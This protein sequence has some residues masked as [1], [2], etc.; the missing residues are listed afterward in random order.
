MRLWLKIT[1]GISIS[2]L[3]VLIIGGYIFY[4]MLN[5][6]LP[7][8]QG[9]L[10]A[11]GLKEK[12]EIYRDSMAVPYIFANNDEDAAFAL[13]YVHAQERMFMMDL[14]RRAGAG[15]LSEVMGKE[16]I[17]FDIMF[18]TVGINR[19]VEKIKNKMNP[20]ALQLL[21]AYSKGVNYYIK[22]ARNK[23]TFEFDMLG[24]QPEEW[25]P[26][27]SLIVIR[28]MAWELNLSWWTDI[29]FT[30]LV[31][32]LGKENVEEIL[33]DYPEN[34]PTIIP[35]HLKKFTAISRTFLEIDK[36][37]RKFM[38]MDGTHIGSNNWVVNGKMSS[39]GKPI[40]ANDPHLAF[41]VPGKWYAAVIKSPNWDAAGVTL[42]GVPGIVI[43]KNKN[44][45]WVLT[46]I[47]NDDSDFYFEE[48]DSSGT[49]YFLDDK[50]NDLK[51]IEDTIFVR[52]DGPVP[53]IIKETHRGPVIS[54]IHS[55]NI[56]YNED[57]TTYPPISMRW[58]G[59]EVSDEAYAFLKIN[60]AANWKEFKSAV[61]LFNVPG[62]N[63]VYGDAE[64]NIGYIF[65][66]ALPL[67]GNGTLNSTT[68][69]FDGTTS[70]SDWTG[71]FNRDHV[72]VLY[73]PDQNFIASANN[74]T[75]KD[76]KYHITNLWEPPSRIERITE[77]LKSKTKHSVNDFMQY[78]MDIVSPYAKSIVSYFLGA[79]DSIDVKDDKLLLAL[80]LLKDW[81][82]KLDKFAQAPTIYLTT[83]K[84]LLN[85]VF[86]DKMG[87]DL[88]NQ[89]VFL[90]NVPYRSINQ[91]LD[92]TDSNWWDDI[93]TQQIENRDDIIRKSMDDALVYLQKN[94]GKE[95][96]DW[97]WGKL[98]KVVFKHPFSGNFSLLD[99]FIN[100]GPFEL[101]GDGTTI[102]N[103]EYPFSESIEEYP[104]FRHD[105]FENDLG[106]S[107][108]YIYDFANPD[109]FYLILTTGESGNIMSKH[110]GDM[111][112]L[113]LEGKYM[114]I[115]TNQ[116]S[117]KSPMNRLLILLP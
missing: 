57:H 76:F 6:S 106:P 85:N 89:Y 18:R 70:E 37:F 115:R 69:V 14:V 102:F 62:Q 23:Y 104:M 72:P 95:V 9:N 101:G 68:F 55:F 24:Y 51:I 10:K 45:S 74:K 91:L 12:V 93:N 46:N 116:E 8:Y 94:V 27:H 88:F 77:L 44:I 4:R 22:E 113:W 81:D 61:K 112:L 50:W 54:N 67:R 48:F 83:F 34:A 11:P 30:E 29:S 38:R 15:R 73:N 1:I 96:K 114:K 35:D 78:Q 108:R 59:N 110:Y 103:T 33:P 42:P 99:K 79:Y 63:F 92:S 21:E 100:I 105:L 28:M 5:N 32:K 41:S 25:K 90:S 58:L 65:G 109:E 3:L 111:S 82:F 7:I 117:I 13:G 80:Q 60:K 107:M 56:V 53:I 16:T 52:G 75:E 47:M 2:L 31:Q 64:G 49:K 71:L 40:I 39:S 84:F 86:L 87:D 19:T 97:Q 98:H 66:G 36:Q 43:G 17:P 26:E 20:A